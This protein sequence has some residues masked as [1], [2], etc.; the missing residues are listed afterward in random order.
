MINKLTERGRSTVFT[1]ALGEQVSL[2]VRRAHDGPAASWV[3]ACALVILGSLLPWGRPAWIGLGAVATAAA[4]LRF[5]A[6]LLL[7]S[8]LI[9]LR[10][11]VGHSSLS[12][13]ELVLP[14]AWASE[15]LRRRSVTCSKPDSR[16]ILACVY[17]YL[18]VAILSG[19]HVLSEFLWLR[20]L[21]LLVEQLL[22]AGTFLLWVSRVGAP[23]VHR[24]WAAGGI[25][26]ALVA[27]LWFFGLHASQGLNLQ[28][29]TNADD[30]VSQQLR[31]GSP[32]W[33]PSNYYA[34]CMLLFLPFIASFKS[35]TSWIRVTSLVV[36]IVS[37]VATLSRGGLISAA[38]AGVLATV[39][40]RS[41]RVAIRPYTVAAGGLGAAALLGGG[42]YHQALAQRQLEGYVLADSSRHALL[43]DSLARFSAH[44]WRGIGLGNTAA[45]DSTTV[46]GVHNYYLQIGLELG[47]VGVL[48]F[49]ITGIVILRVAHRNN[50]DSGRACFVAVAAV[51]VNIL[52]E[53]SFEGVVFSWL[54]AA[55]VGILLGSSRSAIPTNERIRLAGAC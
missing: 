7:L 44:P 40:Y 20:A 52:V 28:P 15:C 19:Y 11:P 45:L 35:R 49:C 6:P 21:T 36:V 16:S 51:F 53:A 29:P 12:A 4:V 9:P 39:R 22:I 37:L 34:S 33:G 27:L 2:V 55:V 32:F 3:L 17:V 23:R 46:K 5:G 43:V 38:F 50:T 8:F 18:L 1:Q 24:F 42:V 54:F 10:F 31:L 14:L 13:V 47:V 25:V 41:V 26:A 48:I 30:A